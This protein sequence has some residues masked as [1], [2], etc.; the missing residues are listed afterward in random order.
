MARTLTRT[1]NVCEAMCG[2]LVSVEDG[3]ITD[4]RGDPDDVFSRGHLCPKGPAMRE[5]LEDPARLK[6]PLRRT[7]TGWEELSWEAAFTDA[8]ARLRKVQKEHGPDALGVYVG[9]PTVHN[10]GASLLLSPFLKA[11]RTKNRFDANSQ[12][13]NPKLFACMEMYG[14]RSSITL[15]D[16]DRTDYLLMLGANPAASNGSLMTLGDVR[17]R[18]QGIRK[19]GGK[20]VLLDPRRTESAA[21]ADAHHALRPGGDAAFLLAVLHTLFAE[22]KVD[23]AALAG[24]ARGLVG[25]EAFAARFPPERVAAAVGL[26]ADAIRGIARDFAAAKRAVAYGR[27][28]TCTNEFGPV[29]SWL[30]EALNVVTGNFDREGGAMFS[31]PAVDVASLLSGK[32]GYARWRSRVRGLPE[33]GGNLPATVMAEEMETAGPGQIRAF[34]TLAGNPVL[35]VPNGPRLARALAGLDTYVAVDFYLNETTRHAHLILPPVHALERSHFDVVFNSLA[36]RNVAKFSEPVV[37]PAPDSRDDWEILLELGMRLGGV[38]LGHPLLDGLVRVLHEGG[39]K[40][41]PDRVLDL[42][43]RAGPYG[44]KLRPWR[45]GLTLDEV[46]LAKHGIDLGPLV[47]QRKRRVR[48]P[49]GLVDLAPATLLGDA[50]RLDTW[51]EAQAR[52][53]L[54]LI[55]RRHLRTNN[56]WMHNCHSLT[57]GKD[58]ATLLVHPED[59][60]RLGLKAG[61]PAKITSR[62]GSAVAPVEISD[63]VRP[64]VV[65]LPHGYGH[66]DLPREGVGAQPGAAALPGPNINAVTDDQLVEPLVG[67]AVLNGVPVQVEAA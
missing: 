53:G 63:E 41:H 17:G 1:C 49:E 4:V 7:A 43:L 14:S 29:A 42:L 8:A 60:A 55:G 46:R 18:L 48:H 59:A 54:V 10:H 47:P 6:R 51:L 36:V 56:S 2:L 20:V 25:L 30:V 19:R 62:A 66:Q 27:V 37:A 39:L 67:T 24:S 58:R 64:G 44:D 33:F 50:S 52:G 57:K 13:A 61:A 9:N 34:L 15:P 35:S 32:R 22:E 65:S 23:R 31:S 11:L 45:S 12:D 38:R 28:G 40:L 26:E 16:V 3:K 21:W 5:V